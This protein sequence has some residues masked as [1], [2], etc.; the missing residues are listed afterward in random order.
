[1][2]KIISEQDRY[3]NHCHSCTRKISTLSHCC[4][5]ALLH[6]Y[7][8]S[9]NDPF[10]MIYSKQHLMVLT[11]SIARLH[12]EQ[13]FQILHLNPHLTF[14]SFKK[15]ATTRAFEHG[16]PLENIKAQETWKSGAV[17]TYLKASTTVTSPVSSTLKQYL[18][19]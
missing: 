4:L 12:L 17:W 5:Y 1:M 8:G 2:S 10:F 3:T 13:I 9:D 18:F 19:L 14:L 15:A 16:V 6:T 7:P 11:D